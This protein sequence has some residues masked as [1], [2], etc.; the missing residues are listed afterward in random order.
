M[1]WTGGQ[2]A[3]QQWCCISSRDLIKTHYWGMEIEEEKQHSARES[4]ARPQEFCSSGV[5]STIVVQLLPI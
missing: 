2:Q 5:C 4:N 3:Y 1:A